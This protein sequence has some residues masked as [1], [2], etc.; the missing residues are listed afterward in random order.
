MELQDQDPQ[1]VVP[2]GRII[3]RCLEKNMG[4]LQKRGSV[5]QQ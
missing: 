2:G 4:S 3:P 5:A 1:Q